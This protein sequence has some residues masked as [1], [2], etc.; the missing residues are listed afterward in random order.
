MFL[1]EH[2]V[3]TSFSLVKKPTPFSLV[4]IFVEEL[5][6]IVHPMNDLQMFFNYNPFFKTFLRKIV[7]A[8]TFDLISADKMCIILSKSVLCGSCVVFSST[9]FNSDSTLLFHCIMQVVY[10]FN[11]TSQAF[12]LKLPKGYDLFILPSCDLTNTL[13]T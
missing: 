11:F 6:K 2:F 3:D 10:C 12:F 9:T 7:L 8:F 5:F 1:S 13:G 4:P